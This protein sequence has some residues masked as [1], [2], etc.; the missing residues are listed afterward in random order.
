LDVIISFVVGTY[1]VGFLFL[2]VSPFNAWFG[3][4]SICIGL[5]A[6]LGARR[7]VERGPYQLVGLVMCASF[8]LGGPLIL[9]LMPVSLIVLNFFVRPRWRGGKIRG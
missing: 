8:A 6:I 9:V 2:S 1:A 4:L 5:S 7:G 3:I